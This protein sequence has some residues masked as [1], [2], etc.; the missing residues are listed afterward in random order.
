MCI[1]LHQE[2]LHVKVL[3]Y[4]LIINE[5]ADLRQRQIVEKWHCPVLQC[6]VDPDTEAD[7]SGRSEQSQSQ[8]QHG[9][10]IARRL[11]YCTTA[12]EQNKMT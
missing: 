12:H 6:W 9:I 3:F 11:Q 10:C 1:N 7:A 8:S 4:M 5:N 2:V